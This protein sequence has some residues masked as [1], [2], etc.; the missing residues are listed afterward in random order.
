MSTT[1][2]G[3]H[4]TASPLWATPHRRGTRDVCA[5]LITYPR[6]HRLQHQYVITVIT[7]RD[8]PGLPAVTRAFPAATYELSVLTLQPAPAPVGQWKTRDLA[9]TSAV[10]VV[11]QTVMIQLDGDDD[12][13]QNTLTG[14]LARLCTDG[15]LTP[16][17]AYPPG[18]T[19]SISR[20]LRR[21][22][23]AEW[24]A[25]TRTTLETIRGRPVTA[26]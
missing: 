21:A 9:A 14:R 20:P 13:E 24:L 22:H 17:P 7:L 5:W 3:R 26:R 1:Y 8:M 12:T 2:T 19:R 16:D 10:P 23:A 4:G 18:A 6:L 15:L 11:A 25:T